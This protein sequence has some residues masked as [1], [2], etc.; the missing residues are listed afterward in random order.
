MSRQELRQAVVGA[1]HP[2]YRADQL[3]D[4]VFAKGATDPAA[5]TNLPKDLAE[6]A[7][8]G[9]SVA[10]RS[11]S[12]DG[13]IKLLIAMHDRQTVECVLIPAR[14]RATAC[15]STQAG[16]P[17]GCAFC[18]S[19]I[20]GL[21]R[22]LS[23]DEILEQTIHLRQAGAQR[24]SH[25]VIMGMGEPLANY[26][27]TVAAIR[28]LIDPDRV[29]ISARNITVSTVGLPTAIRRLAKEDLPITLAISLHA[30]NDQLRRRLI[31]AAHGTTIAQILAAA[32]DFVASRNRRLTLEYLLLGEVNDSQ[33]CADELAGLAR[34]VHS[35]VNLI[36]YNTVESLPFKPSSAAATKAFGRAA[37]PAR[38]QCYAATVPRLRYRRRLRPTPS[39]ASADVG[40]GCHASAC[41][42]MPN[43][44]TEPALAVSVLS[45]RSAA[46]LEASG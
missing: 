31:P 41:G 39:T 33:K 43:Q 23:A 22:D 13:T 7:T 5:M 19:G 11:D 36:R 44:P 27:A 46:K 34:S 16:C 38:R 37:P 8:L 18:A 12:R 1:G 15:L 17:I 28:G 30:P 6:L 3:A 24:I 21:R 26:D 9:S 32:R 40:A 45:R 4:W 35:H 14:H 29:G 10:V 25:V 2:A 42:S 20:G